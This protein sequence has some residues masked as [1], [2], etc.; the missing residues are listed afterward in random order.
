M[1]F[2]EREICRQSSVMSFVERE[3]CKQSSVVSFVEREICK[4]SQSDINKC[5]LLGGVC[6][7]NWSTPYPLV[8]L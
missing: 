8:V 6:A 4:Q 2:V 7:T 1:S 5:S 3:I